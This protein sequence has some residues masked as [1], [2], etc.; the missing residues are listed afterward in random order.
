MGDSDCSMSGVVDNVTKA[1]IGFFGTVDE[2]VVSNGT[3]R[4]E[5]CFD[6]DRDSGTV[7]LVKEGDGNNIGAVSIMI[8]FIHLKVP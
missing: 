5:S 8:D 2:L 4:V 7:G 1:G 3:I 6:I